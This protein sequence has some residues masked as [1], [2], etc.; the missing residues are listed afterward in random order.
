MPAR[1]KIVAGMLLLT[2]PLAVHIALVFD[3]VTIASALLLLVS[4]ICM[5]ASLTGTTGS[6]GGR[7]SFPLLFG[8]LA[9]LSFLNL[10]SNT[11]YALYFPPVLINLAML[12]IFANTLRTGR[13]P[14]I[15]EFHRLTA[16][17]GVD[18]AMAVYTRRL[19]WLWAILFT[20]MALES[21]VLAVF[22]TLATWS[23]FANFL[24]YVFVIA[25][26]VG[27]YFYRIVRYRHQKHPSLVQF[28]RNLAQTDW[29]RHS[30][31]R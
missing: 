12:A 30:H 8:A 4:V 27:E 13:E 26:L 3:R 5:V 21:A 19:T 6:Q 22:A 1:R 29:M 23:L 7:Q 10:I 14:L 20:A 18:S 9:V 31:S 2:Y 15:T 17:N 11:Q 28:L 25:L 24:N 16:N